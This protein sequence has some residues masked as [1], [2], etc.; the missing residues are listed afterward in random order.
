MASRLVPQD[1]GF[2]QLA[3]L[4]VLCYVVSATTVALLM[5]NEW[6]LILPP[7]A[8]GTGFLA[9]GLAMRKQ[10]LCRFALFVAFAIFLAS[11]IVLGSSSMALAYLWLTMAQFLMLLFTVEVV[12]AH[13]ATFGSAMRHVFSRLGRIS[14]ILATAYVISLG[15]ITL[16][17]S[18]VSLVPLVADVSLYIVIISV[19]LPLLLILREDRPSRRRLGE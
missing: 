2:P 19:S 18:L 8:L 16:G 1:I 15:S 13:F 12:E 6:L 5:S 11:L 17:T 14:M 3:G 9:I 10:V 4:A 7:V